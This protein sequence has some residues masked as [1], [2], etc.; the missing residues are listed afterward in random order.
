MAAMIK[1]AARIQV[2]INGIHTNINTV[3]LLHLKL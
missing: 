2:G 1:A 3:K